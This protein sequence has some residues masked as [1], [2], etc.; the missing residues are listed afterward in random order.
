MKKGSKKARCPQGHVMKRLINHVNPCY[1]C[2]KCK[3]WIHIKEYNE[4]KKYYND[5]RG[6]DK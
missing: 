1:W 3:Y 6:L 4:M 5:K 2:P